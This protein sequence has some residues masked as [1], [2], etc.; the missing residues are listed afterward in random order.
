MQDRLSLVFKIGL[1]FGNV[2]FILMEVFGLC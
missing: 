2:F 1:L